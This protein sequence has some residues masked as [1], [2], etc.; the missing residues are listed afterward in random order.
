MA[1]APKF[2][3]PKKGSKA[4][5]PLRDT[6]F[7]LF[8]HGKSFAEI[9]GLLSIP[10]NRLSRWRGEDNW[11]D[12]LEKVQAKYLERL[13]ERLAGRR[14]AADAKAITS[15]LSLREKL[16]TA[17]ETNLTQIDPDKLSG[18]LRA[19]QDV[20]S[21]ITPALK[22]EEGDGPAEATDFEFY[23]RDYSA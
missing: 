12:R 23:E 13:D 11:N 18:A 14:A 16:I 2:G 9:E 19:V 7:E 1:E 17:M 8:A 21:K 15:L 22:P 10:I 5:N 3:R 6:A 4:R 20:V